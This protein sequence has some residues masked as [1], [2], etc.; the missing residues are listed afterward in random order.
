[1]FQCSPTGGGVRCVHS[2]Q[3][4]YIYYTSACS[5]AHSLGAVYGVFI[6][7]KNIL[8]IMLQHVPMLPHWGAVCSYGGPSLGAVYGYSQGLQFLCDISQEYT[9]ACASDYLPKFGR[10]Q[11]GPHRLYG[12]YLGWL[13]KTKNNIP[14]EYLQIDLGGVYWV[15]GVA[16]QGRFLGYEWTT[17]YKISLSMNNITWNI[18]QWNGSDKVG[19]VLITLRACAAT[20][21][22]LKL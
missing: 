13:A 1:M 10:L 6:A 15:C 2:S 8:Y 11:D 12:P 16:T 7:H 3:E 22:L 4:C 17:K 20:L 9:S 18:Y 19:P 5:N 21:L 14:N